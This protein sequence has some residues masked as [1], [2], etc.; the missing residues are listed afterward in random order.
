M[1]AGK[2][3][4]GNYRPRPGGDWITYSSRVLRLPFARFSAPASG[5]R[6][7]IAQHLRTASSAE[8]SLNIASGRMW[9]TCQLEP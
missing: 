2:D 8:A 6:F 4:A 7:V 3:L 5:R 1:R 9:S